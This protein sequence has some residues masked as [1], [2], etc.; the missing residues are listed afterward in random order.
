MK[1]L[2]VDDHRSLLEGL[3]K[4][5]RRASPASEVYS[6]ANVGDALACAQAKGCDVLFCEIELYN[7][8]GISLAEQI[9][10]L[11]PRV[12]IIFVTVCSENEHARDVLRLRPSGYLLK[13]PS[14]EQIEKELQNLRH[15]VREDDEMGRCQ[16]C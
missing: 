12:N 15:P 4:T 11:F 2:C 10:T 1:I 13:P 7:L 16:S 8:G 3:V 9:Q 6:A 5:V 14:I